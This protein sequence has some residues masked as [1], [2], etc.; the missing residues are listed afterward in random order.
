MDA[1]TGP[2]SS[3]PPLADPAGV[4]D[5]GILHAHQVEPFEAQ[6]HLAANGLVD[7]V[8]IHK[9]AVGLVLAPDQALRRNFEAF[10]N[11]KSRFAIRV[12]GPTI[13]GAHVYDDVAALLSEKPLLWREKPQH[14]SSMQ[15]SALQKP[16]QLQL[17]VEVLFRLHQQLV[18]LGLLPSL[19]EV[20]HE[21]GWL[22]SLRFFEVFEN[23]FGE[24]QS[25]GIF[26]RDSIFANEV[27]LP[28][29]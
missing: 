16:C 7:A 23:I 29:L 5:R 18:A 10:L 6:G 1:L 27:L 13:A 17:S 25:F 22:H 20:H 28:F 4:V 8:H 15:A 26:G 21:V 9:A 19:E 12:T 14:C 24:V 3:A 11:G 2:S